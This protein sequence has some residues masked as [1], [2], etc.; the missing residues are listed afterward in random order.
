MA[1]RL[2]LEAQATLRTLTGMDRDNAANNNN[3]N[4][5]SYV[6]MNATAHAIVKNKEKDQQL[7]LIAV[8]RRLLY[9][10]PLPDEE[11]A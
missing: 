10:C 8:S 2:P 5:T 1:A 4:A 3:K 11:E 7:H 6:N 9:C